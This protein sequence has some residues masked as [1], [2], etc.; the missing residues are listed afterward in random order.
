MTKA[1][2]FWRRLLS[3]ANVGSRPFLAAS[4]VEIREF[5]A[6][7]FLLDSRPPRTAPLE[8][9]LSRFSMRV[10]GGISTAEIQIRS[11]GLQIDSV[12]EGDERRLLVYLGNYF[13][14]PP[15]LRRAGVATACI[16]AVRQAFQIAA[17]DQ[18]WPD[19]KTV[20]EG[21]FIG[22]GEHWALAM[23]NGKLPTKACAAEV[24]LG[25][26]QTAESKLRWLTQPAVQ[27]ECKVV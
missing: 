27:P 8:I 26:L 16:A 6:A 5:S 19:Q 4:Q 24:N 2:A 18:L 13:I 20:L 7:R 14:V 3:K 11:H 25:R 23:C 12:V 10:E 15:E 21:Y 9:A 17:F 22:P 1:L